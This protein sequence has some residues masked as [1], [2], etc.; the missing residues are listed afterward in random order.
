MLS[1]IEM[2]EVAVSLLFLVVNA[3]VAVQPSSSP[4]NTTIEKLQQK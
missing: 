3:W 2:T 1:N 4:D